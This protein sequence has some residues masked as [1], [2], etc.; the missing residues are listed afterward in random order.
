MLKD[1][2]LS[3]LHPLDEPDSGV[4]SKYCIYIFFDVKYNFSFL[5]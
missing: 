3:A 1:F 4:Q 2:K 5:Y